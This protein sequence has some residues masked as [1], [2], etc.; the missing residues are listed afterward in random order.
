MKRSAAYDRIAVL[1]YFCTNTQ[2]HPLG[3]L[4]T[5]I[6]MPQWSLSPV[7]CT[8]THLPQLQ[9]QALS[10]PVSTTEA[11]GGQHGDGQSTAQ[12]GKVGKGGR[13]PGVKVTLCVTVT[14]TC[15][16]QAAL[17]QFGAG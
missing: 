16:G 3:P 9:P 17:E 13:G 15:P 6:L 14:L 1:F 8:A 5:F 7:P 4:S 2:Q 11:Q 12:P 10:N